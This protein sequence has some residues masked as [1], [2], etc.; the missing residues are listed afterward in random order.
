MKFVIYTFSFFLLK[1]ANDSFMYYLFVFPGETTFGFVVFL[2]YVCFLFH[3]F[4]L[5]S[6]FLS[7]TFL[8]LY[9]LLFF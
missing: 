7:S 3:E 8:W 9:L 4:V 5:L 2:C 1:F 6:L